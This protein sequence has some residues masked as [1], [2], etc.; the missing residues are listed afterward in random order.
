MRASTIAALGLGLCFAPLAAAA[1]QGSDEAAI[2]EQV[3]R[4]NRMIAAKDLDGVV[5]LY[6]ADA[7][8][9]TPNAPAVTGPALREAWKGLLGAPE[10]KATLTP[11]EVKVAA[12]RDLAYERG[13]YSIGMGGAP[14]DVGKYIVV[15]RK[16]GGQWKV[17]AD[18]FNSDQAAPAR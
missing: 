15:W 3:A 14:P 4:W 2:R 5:G 11:L 8:F 10:L 13:A 1:A 16:S 6:A 9:M 7:Y 17:A 12:S 18:I